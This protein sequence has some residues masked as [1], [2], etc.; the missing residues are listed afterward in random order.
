MRRGVV[1]HVAIKL[2]T[3]KGNNLYMF[4]QDKLHQ[5][6]VEEL[7]KEVLINLASNEYSKVLNLNKINS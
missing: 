6:I 1:V 4:W 7:N 2:K 5:N 3:I